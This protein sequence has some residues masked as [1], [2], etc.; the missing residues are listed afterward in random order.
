MIQF[1][2]AGVLQSFAITDFFLPFI[3][4][5]TVVFAVLQKTKILGDKKNFNVVVSLVMGLL[6]VVPHVTGQYPLTYDPVLIMIQVLPSI[7]LVAVASIMLLVL[8]GVFG[9]D[10][11][12]A[13][14]PIIATLSIAFVVYI[15]GSTAP[16][17][18][19]NGPFDRFNWWTPQITELLII[20]LVFGLVV[21]VIV[22]EPSEKSSGGELIKSF[23]KLF[24]K[25]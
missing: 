7:S 20:I 6:F 4:V 12:N 11:S 15:F 24:T 21:W 16:F 3:L 8:M 22:R 9:T 14:A 1:N 10:F 2:I 5:F 25:K 23:G 17:N 19:W 18:W 13:A